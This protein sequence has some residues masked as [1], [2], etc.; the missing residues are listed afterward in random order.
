MRLWSPIVDGP[1]L[2]PDEHIFLQRL[3]LAEGSSLCLIATSAATK[4]QLQN[5]QRRL[6][7]GVKV[8]NLVCGF[9]MIDGSFPSSQLTNVLYS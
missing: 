3:L 1:F 7:S 2:I 9:F 5:L 8:E 6:S 4:S